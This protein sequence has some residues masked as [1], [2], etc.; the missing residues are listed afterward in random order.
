MPAAYH[1]GTETIRQLGGSRPIYSVDG[2]IVGLVVLASRGAV[3]ELTLCQT[4]RDFAQ[5]GTLTGR[6]FTAADA[7]DILARYQAGQYYVVNVLDPA[8]HISNVSGETLTVDPL[9][10]RATTAHPAISSVVVKDGSTTLTEGT[11]YTIIDAERGEI[12]LKSAP[13]G[14]VTVSYTYLDPSKVEHDDIVGGYDVSHAKRTGLE[15]LTEG[16][17]K[18]GA[19]AKIVL[20]PD[21]D[22]TQAMAGEMETIAE[23]IKAVAYVA[24]PKGTKLSTALEGRGANGT[25]NFRSS[26]ERVRH[27]YPYA[28]GA[29]RLESLAT[30]AA[31]MRML[32]DVEHGYWYSSSNRDLR[33]VTGLET[34]LTA[35]V[36]DPQSETNLL[37]ARGITT[38]FNSYGTGFRLWGNRSAAFPT[39]THIVNFETAL[40]TG[41]IIDESIRRFELQ[42]LDYPIDDALIDSLIESIDTYMRGQESLVGYSVALD[43]DYSE[44]ELVDAFSRGQIPIFYDYTPKIPGE[45]ITNRSV[46]TRRYL[47]NLV[48]SK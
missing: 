36:D 16:F 14:A 46:M 21:K 30:H 12:Q 22:S 11:K 10:L 6:G 47:V 9:T 40:R 27:F 29:D 42:Y 37:N 13:S 17:N 41:D 31:G 32:V 43:P 26:S 15:L 5:F 25:I 18:F 28:K 7:F 35:R 33:G 8:K 19:D 45:R 3:N 39:V 4:M 20:V 24:A 48:S 34:P 44:A 1:H 23:R 38:I 2:A